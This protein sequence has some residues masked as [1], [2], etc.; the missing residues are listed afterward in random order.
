M[1]ARSVREGEGEGM[2]EDAITMY[3]PCVGCGTGGA[4]MRLVVDIDGVVPTRFEKGLTY[5][6]CPKCGRATLPEN[7]NAFNDPDGKVAV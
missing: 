6:R 5:L 7:W 3:N 4:N 2:S 1:G